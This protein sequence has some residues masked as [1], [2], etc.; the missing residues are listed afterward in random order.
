M[1][2]TTKSGKKWQKQRK[3]VKN[4]KKQFV[5]KMECQNIIPPFGGIGDSHVFC[6]KQKSV[7]CLHIAPVLPANLK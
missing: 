7:R 4:S 2:K 5:K 3:S 1:G 6:E